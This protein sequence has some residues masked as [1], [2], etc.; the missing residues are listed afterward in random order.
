MGIG[1]RIYNAKAGDIFI[2]RPKER[3]WVKNYSNEPFRILVFKYNY[4]ENDIFW[5]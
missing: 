1:E 3:H 2:C 5:E 4:A